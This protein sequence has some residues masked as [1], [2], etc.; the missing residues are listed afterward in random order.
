MLRLIL[1]LLL[2]LHTLYAGEY[3]KIAL[4]PADINYNKEDAEAFSEMLYDA[5]S[6]SIA[7]YNFSQSKKEDMYKIM[8]IG[9][10]TLIASKQYQAKIHQ[11]HKAAAKNPKEF[12]ESNHLE[13]ILLVD[14][15]T[16]KILKTMKSCRSK[17]P[18]TISLQLFKTTGDPFFKK[19][20][21]QYD[22]KT[23]MLADESIEQ[24]NSN[25]SQ[26]LGK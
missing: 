24:L 26:L 15:S 17:C 6:N 14:F 7:E 8:P 1:S 4:I 13:Q 18:V 9:E 23:C 12:L 22:A 25:I 11:V 10:T 5:L 20:T 19:Y 3:K 16:K 21:L 2:L